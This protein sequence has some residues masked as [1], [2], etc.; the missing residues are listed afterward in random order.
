MRSGI[1]L[2]INIRSSPNWQ[3]AK[4]LT[5]HSN[6]FCSELSK[7]SLLYLKIPSSLSCLPSLYFR[8]NGKSQVCFFG[9]KNFFTMRMIRECPVC[10]RS[11]LPSRV[12]QLL[13]QH[14]L[15]LFYFFDYLGFKRTMRK[16]FVNGW[17]IYHW[18][19]N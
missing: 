12:S 5:P 9:C 2:I 4:F 11:N 10:D 17:A 1:P 14:T 6:I 7:F 16:N 15:E 18:D 19:W 8:L 13:S 3:L